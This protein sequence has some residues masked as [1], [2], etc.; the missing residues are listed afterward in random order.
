[1]KNNQNDNLTS[2]AAQSADGSA[3][4]DV[5]RIAPGQTLYIPAR[6]IRWN[7]LSVDGQELNFQPVSSAG[8]VGFLPVYTSEA[9][10]V[11]KHGPEFIEIEASGE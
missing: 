1:M 6:I 7:A 4:R 5:L 2:T 8:A 9:D 10:C 11:R 3:V